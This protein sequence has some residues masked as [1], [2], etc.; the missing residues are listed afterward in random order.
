MFASLLTGS[1]V[2]AEPELNEALRAQEAGD[3]ARAASLYLPL[4]AKGNPV[5]QYN[6]G[7]LYAQ[8][9]VIQKDY[10]AAVQWYLAAA[11]QGHAQA[12]A[13]LGLLYVS[14]KGVVQDYKKAMKWFVASAG[15]GNAVAQLHIGELYVDGL[16]VLQDEVEAIKW[17]R[18]AAAQGDAVAQFKLG[19]CYERGQGVAQDSVEAGR[20]LHVAAANATDA[21]S[22]SRYLARRD[23]INKA[24]ER[25]KEAKTKQEAAAQAQRE[26]AEGAARAE[27]VRREEAERIEAERIEAQRIAQVKA[28]EQAKHEDEARE[29][30]EVLAQ[31]Q[32]KKQAEIAAAAQ[33]AKAARFKARQYRYDRQAGRRV[34]HQAVLPQT[35]QHPSTPPA[36]EVVKPEPEVTDKPVGV[37]VA[38]AD[39]VV[40]TAQPAAFPREVVASDLVQAYEPDVAKE[41]TD[42]LPSPDKGEV[43]P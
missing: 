37:D 36:S 43:K 25:R 16:G 38:P 7:V 9:Q 30:R 23:E 35:E 31:T 4:A 21:A 27:A 32:A 19:E 15:Q 40:L 1:A 11:E 42:I 17:Y 39:T 8:G 41:P 28:V 24:L 18:Q 20:W 10:R 33:E 12:Q 13:Q 22:R 3:Y 5:A 14:G 6:L 34:P 29:V 26:Q 2:H